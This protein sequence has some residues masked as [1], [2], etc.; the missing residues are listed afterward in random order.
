MVPHVKETM[1]QLIGSCTK[2]VPD[3]ELQSIGAPAALVWGEGDRFVPLDLAQ[4]AHA[5]L[6]WPLHVIKDAGHAAHIEQPEAFRRVLE[7]VT[8]THG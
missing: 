7:A 3:S 1:R 8:S 5:R 2:Q 4:Q 6:G